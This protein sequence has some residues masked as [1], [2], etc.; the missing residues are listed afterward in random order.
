MRIGLIRMR[1]TPYGGAETF[2]G[3]FMRGLVNKGHTIDVFSTGWEEAPGVRLHKINVSGPSF[4]RPLI[5]ASRV[6]KEVERVKPDLVISLERTYS[7]DIY[8]AGDGCHKEWLRRRSAAL[9]PLKRLTMRLNPLHTTLLYLE[10]RLL[11]SPRLKKVVANSGR[12]KRDIM[13]HYGLPDE[14][15]CVIYNGVEPP[16]YSGK[17]DEIRGSLGMGKDTVLILFVGSGFERKGLIYLIRAMARLKDRDAK[18]VVIGK[19]R[20]SR[21]LKEARALGVADRVV[22]IGP[23]KG[24]SPYYEAADIFCLPSIYEPFSNACLEAMAAGLPVVTSRINGASEIIWDG[25]AGSHIEEP[26]DPDE[27]ARLLGAFFDKEKRA[28]AGEF[29][30]KTAQEYTIDK[31]VDSFLRLIETM[32]MGAS[33]N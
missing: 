19:G 22:F 12:V 1:Y 28:A 25:R 7:Q 8:R 33:K 30:R 16:K 27:I 21:Y 13:N 14:K 3:R 31:T 17:R 11:N 18:L 29:A 26:T 10:K 32:Q 6:E 15:I 24:V 5:F 23:V 9:P 20:T 4:L 2:L